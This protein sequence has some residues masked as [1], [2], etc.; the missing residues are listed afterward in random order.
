MGGSDAPVPSRIRGL[1]YDFDDTIVESERINDRLFAG[2]LS[3]EY[4]IALTPAELDTLYG[5]A[6]SGVF[7]WLAEHRGLAPGRN[8]VWAR[9]LQIKREFLRGARLRVAT[10]IDRMLALPVPHAVVSGS[11]REEVRM[12]LD[13]IQVPED[14][15]NFILCDEDCARGKPDPEGFLIARARLGLP[16]QELLAFEDSVPG[17]QAAQGAGISVA[18]LAELASRDNGKEADLRFQSF[19]D[20]C[21]WVTGRIVKD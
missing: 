7:A 10:G 5:F 2:L 15:F 13:N 19:V 8:E 16:P 20:A 17:I 3:R 14:L 21:A 18:F 12:M 4:G 11:T 1:I 9:F 6:W